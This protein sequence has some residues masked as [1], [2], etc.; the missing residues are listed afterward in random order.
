VEVLAESPSTNAALAAR[1]RAGAAAGLVLVAEHQTAG[2]GRLDRSWVTPPRAALTF[3]MLLA[4]TGVPS[5]RW[6]W[7]PLLVGVAV[8]DGVARATG[9]Q[10]GLKWPNDVQV[11]ERK[12]AGILVERVDGPRGAAAVVGIGLNVSTG[13]DELPVQTATSLALEGASVDRTTLLGELLGAVAGRYAGWCEVGGDATRGL[14]AA[15][16]QVSSTIGRPVRVDLPHGEQVTGEAVG[17]DE[18]GRLR[19]ATDAG[20]RVLGAGDVVHVRVQ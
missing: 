2:R 17:V 18:G 9:V 20:E 4:P 14:L 16:T 5:A 8:A 13:R 11:G 19:V 12:L 3:S 15:Y 6:P 10:C 7:L 1:A